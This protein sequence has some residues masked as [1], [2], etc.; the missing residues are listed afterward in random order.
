ML[1]EIYLYQYITP[2]GFEN[3]FYGQITIRPLLIS[4]SD[5]RL[6]KLQPIKPN[7]RKFYF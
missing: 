5:Y 4:P 7:A 1:V 3:K 2:F 6:T